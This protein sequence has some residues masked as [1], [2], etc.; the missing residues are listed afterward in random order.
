MINAHER[1]RGSSGVPGHS[2]AGVVE[3]KLRNGTGHGTVE[4]IRNYGRAGVINSLEV[5]YTPL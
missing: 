5:Y 1:V 4:R 3:G 2:F